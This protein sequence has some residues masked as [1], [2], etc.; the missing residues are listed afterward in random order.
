MEPIGFVLVAA[1]AVALWGLSK[2]QRKGSRPQGRPPS[3]RRTFV[4]TPR[5]SYP[6]DFTGKVKAEYAPRADGKPD[7]GEIVWTWVPYE[8]DHTR[9]KDRPVLIVGRD[10]IWLL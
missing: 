2:A 8:E 6:G 3:R 10:D 5:Y 4:A 1:V 7:P 9:G